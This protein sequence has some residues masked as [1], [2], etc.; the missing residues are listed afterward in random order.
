MA[1]FNPSNTSGLIPASINF[2]ASS[3]KHSCVFLPN[4]LV[5][6]IASGLSRY[7]SNGLSIS[8][9]S[10][11]SRIKY[12]SSCVL[13]TANEGITTLPPRSNVLVNTFTSSAA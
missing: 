2:I 10:L 9:F 4:M 5:D 13:P 8:F 3:S 7:T 1:N 11:I 12:K 6:S